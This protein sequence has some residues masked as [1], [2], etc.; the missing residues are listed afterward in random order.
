MGPAPGHAL[1]DLPGIPLSAEHRLAVGIGQR[2]AALIALRNAGFPE[3]FL[4]QN[5]DG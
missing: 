1:K 5:V 4:R 3:V 2:L